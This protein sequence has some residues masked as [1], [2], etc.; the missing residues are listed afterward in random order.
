MIFKNKVRVFFPSRWLKSAVLDQPTV[1]SGEVS[2]GRSVAVPVGSLHFNGTSTAL[3]QHFNGTSMHFHGNSTAS[4]RYFNGQKKEKKCTVASISVG[5]V[6]Q[7]LPYAGFFMDNDTF[8][9]HD[10]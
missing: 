8:G 6:I 3:Q 7:C 2:M 4:P 10:L 5:R 9:V 1:G